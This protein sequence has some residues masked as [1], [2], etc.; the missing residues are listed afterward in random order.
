VKVSKSYF[1]HNN[2]RVIIFYDPLYLSKIIHN[3]LKQLGFK[4]GENN[5]VLFYCSDSVLPIKMA[6]TLTEKHVNLPM[7]SGRVKGCTQVESWRHTIPY[8]LLTDHG[9]ILYTSDLSNCQQDVDTFLFNLKCIA[10]VQYNESLHPPVYSSPKIPDAIRCLIFI[11]EEDNIIIYITGYISCKIT[12][13]VCSKC[14]AGLV[15][16][17]NKANS[18]HLFIAAKQYQDL[19]TGGLVVPT[20]DQI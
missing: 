6:P 12:K 19:P 11:L 5:V 14:A 1:I 9:R 15:G 8:C 3:N 20:V 16:L 10:L 18:F 2:N 17:L 4:D 13:M 7:F